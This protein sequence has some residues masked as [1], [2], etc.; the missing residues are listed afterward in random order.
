MLVSKETTVPHWLGV[1]TNEGIP[2]KG[3]YITFF[4]T[5]FFHR[6][7][8]ILYIQTCFDMKNVVL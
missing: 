4:G 1:A 8:L 5:I 3:S 7:S 2:A 6:I